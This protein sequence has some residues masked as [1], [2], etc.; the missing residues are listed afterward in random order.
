MRRFWF[1][2]IVLLISNI[3]LT[4]NEANIWYFG[5]N[6]GL[7]FNSGSPVAL[8]D[9]QLNTLEGCSTISDAN[10]NL[11]FY[12]DGITVWNT[13]HLVM[14][15]G[16]GLNGGTSSTHSALIVPKPNDSNIY[17]IF[18]VDA[19]TG[20]NGLQ[21]SE[22]DMSLDSGLGAITANKNIQLA[23]P[24]T[25]KLTA[26]KSS[27]SNE[28]WVVSHRWG[29]NQFIAY[30]VSST[31]VNNIPVS[32]G[33][34]SFVGGSGNALASVGQIKISPD[35]TKL[36]V[37]RSV[38]YSEAQLFDFEASTGVVSNPITLFDLPDFQSPYGVE[39]S[40][41]SK[42]LY[43]SVTGDGVYQYNLEAGSPTDIINSE[44]LI[45][46][47]PNSYSAL[48]L[49]TDDKIYIAN[50]LAQHLD[51]INEPNNVG[52]TCN[53][54]ADAVYLGGRIVQRGLP[55]FIQSFFNVTFQVN[56]LCLGQPTSFTAN[57]PTTYDSLEWDF[58]DGNTSNL[59]NPTHT[60][61]TAGN[62]NVSLTVTSGTETST[63]SQYITIYE[64]PTATQPQDILICD[65]N[66]DGFYDFDLTTQ[67]LDI[68]N[69]QSL[70]IFEVTYYASMMDYTNNN[71]ITDPN[72]YTNTTAYTSQT[73]VASIRNSNNIDCEDTT[74]FNIEVFES[75]TPSTNIT[76][77][78]FCDNTSIGTDTDGIIEFDLT[79]NE[80]I[81]LNGQSVTDF[82]VNYYTDFGLVNQITNPSTYQNINE[83]ETIYVEVVNNDNLTCVAQ[84][85]FGIIVFEHP[86]V[87]PFVTLR[88]CD[89]DLDGFSVFNLTEVNA[90]LSANHLN[91]T[92]SFYESA[93]EAESE[94]NAIT[95][96]AT[97]TNQTVSTDII[98]ARI[99]N[100]NN[101]H[102]TA[103]VN[104]VVSTTQIPNTYTRDFYQCDDE[105]DITNGIATFDFSSVNTEIQALFP[106]GQQLFINYYRN[107]ADALSETNPIADI[108]NYQNIDYPNMQDIFIR[109]DSAL[110]N[111][112][113]GLGH[114]ITL[115]VET[116]PVANS[117]I[118]AEQCDA[119]GD[120]QFEFDTTT[121]QSTLLNGQTN[122][123]VTY[124]DELGNPLPSPLPNPF[125][126]ATQTIT[127]R[128]INSTSQDPDG[129]CFDETQITFTVDAAAVAYTVPDFI[130]CDD[131]NDGQFAFDTSNVETTVLN[132]QTGMM[133]TYTDED[134]NSLPSP[135][136]NPF[137]TDSQTII[138]RVENQL[139][140][141]C[142]DETT[143]T[144]TV[145]EQ[146]EAF[147]VTDDFVCDDPSNDGEAIFVF[148]DYDVQVLNG[149]SSITFEVIYFDDPNNAQNNQ[150]P[151]ANNYVVSST[152]QPIYARVQN[153]NN[154]NCFAITSFTLGVN[155]LPIANQ[156]DDMSVCDD[157]TNDGEELF[158]LSSQNTTIL[159]GLS[160]TDYTISYHLS[161]NH[162]E[163]DSDAINS[164]FTN[165]D[166]PQTIYARLE[167]NIS[168]G[169]YT[170]TQFDI[171][172]NE[173][174]V[175][176]MDDLWPICEGSTVDIIA[177]AGYDQYIWST[178]ETSQSII[179]DT[180]GTYEVTATNI[181]GDLSCSISKTI[182]VT[183]S[184]IATITD[185]E[186]VDWTQND[187]AITVFVEGNGDYEYSLDGFIYQDSNKFINLTIDEYTIYVRDKNGC[188]VTTESVYLLYYPRFFT[189]NNDGYN[190]IWQIVNSSREP[191]NKIYIFD[192]Y[193]KLLKQL[194]PT[195]IGWDGTYNGSGL[196]TNDYWFMLERQNGRT[197]RGHFTLNR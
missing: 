130:A 141:I 90:E 94:N 53:Y 104:L 195:D 166:T 84:T 155:V 180:V 120:T 35:G 111:D 128:V 160:D 106:V 193:G 168:P 98:W 108:S 175:L 124:V 164:N 36:A 62:Y 63:D 169:C 17:Y 39:F 48:Q 95:N 70:S 157:D 116:V 109:V 23:T 177:D 9:G 82:T 73:V 131:D 13:N 140:A 21:Y 186:T 92:I 46:S 181:Y 122:V 138:V 129:A 51:V 170:T 6:A 115:H 68:S 159:N 71:P 174:P 176:L 121:I 123:N 118:I 184:N 101:C 148:S 19:Q 3:G 147:A 145:S 74:T 96:I 72:N 103:Q 1:F 29:G 167:N 126:T 2:L 97:Y 185:I 87:T 49:A 85:S 113:L 18:T 102:R 28:Y 32:S 143:I 37:V 91:E 149:Q 110:D 22:V 189:P 67:D 125:T 11:L 135:L 153:I 64:Q 34:G 117:V 7:D 15:N 172:V 45:T 132:G 105:T 133:V 136:P 182:T 156:P 83:I 31:G 61:T 151:L 20:S 81:I 50:S 173:Q 79:Q 139:S 197:Y 14:P 52:V 55:P 27:V 187:N 40:P 162:A 89:D 191:N 80:S 154:S 47:N 127:A 10:G 59:E 8:L 93:T 77:L 112:C 107:Q 158:D 69:G 161:L 183:N 58:G 119:D 16:T 30:N 99:Q 192:R 165:T 194:S 86:T 41:N 33:V 188:G 78:S 150:F 24:V 25:E 43:I 57:T 142:F 144:F 137:T 76:N 54:Q 100:S 196:P 146:P 56:N 171:I 88:Q 44:Y 12:S 152:S 5:E 134:G 66:N 114:H 65:D 38:S 178:G 4:Q 163:S 42:V 75:P 60:Y 179:I 26:I 190:D